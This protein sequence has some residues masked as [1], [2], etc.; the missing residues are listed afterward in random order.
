[1]AAHYFN[2][3]HPLPEVCFLCILDFHVSHHL[4]AII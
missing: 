3:K 1:L 4:P 2:S